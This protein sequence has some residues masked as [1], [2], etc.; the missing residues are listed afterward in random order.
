MTT[1]FRS[2]HPDVSIPEDAAIWNKLEQHASQK[3]DKAALICGMTERT[4]SFAQV[5]EQ[6]QQICAGLAAN[7]I[8][9]G[10]GVELTARAMYACGARVSFLEVDADHIL[11]VL[12]FFHIMATMIF[13]VTL[14]KGM[15]LI[16][17]PK[18]EPHSFLR[19]VEQYKLEN[20]NIAP[21]LIM[22]FAKHPA[23]DKYDVSAL[24]RLVSGG[25]PLGEEL[26]SAV[27]K[28]LGVPVMQSYGLTEL[29]GAATNS[30]PTAFRDGASGQLLPNTE[31][32]VRC[33]T[34]GGDLPANRRG[35]LLIRC[36]AMM[37]GY[38]NNPE[39]SRDAF[40]DDGFLRTGDVG[41]IDD[42]GFVFIIDRLK[43]MIK[44]KGHQVAPA[45]LEDV[46]NSHPLVADSCCV[47]GFD[48]A[49]GEEIPKA[50]VVLKDG[51]AALT[52]DGLMAFVAS[53][54]AGY[55]RVREVEFIDVIP[56]SLSGKILRRELQLV[57]DKTLGAVRALRSHLSISSF[58][59]LRSVAQAKPPKPPP[60]IAKCFA[61]IFTSPH[62]KIPIPQDQ[63]IWSM[64]ELH[65]RESGHKPAFICGL[66][67]KTLT[68]AQTLEKAKAVCAG[69]SAHGIKKGDIV[70]LHSFN[71]LEYPVVFLAL[72]RLGAICS[73]SSPMF[74][75]KE[76]ADQIEIAKATAVIGHKIFGDVV[77][78]GAALGGIKPHQV[79]LFGQGEAS[80]PAETI[81]YVLEQH[82]IAKKLPFPN[83][84]PMDPTNVVALP[85]SSGTTGR[86]KGV[87]LTGRA[88]LAT[89]IQT[90]AL[91]DDLTYVLGML[92]FFHILA[93]LI[94]HATIF[95]A[96][97]M[98]I[99]PRFEPES[100]LRVVVKYKMAKLSLAPPLVLFMA[101][102]PIVDKF[103]LSHVTVLASGGAP[104]GKE[105][106]HAIMKRLGAKVLQGYGMTEFAGAV[107]NSTDTHARDGSTGRLLP[108][109]EMKVK[110]LVT[111]ADLHANQTGE[112]L[113][114]TPSMMKG[115]YNNPEA[116]R[117]TF[118][119]DGFVRTGDIGYID[120]D[121]YVF[122]VDRL[123]ELIKY[124][125]HQVAPAELEDV[126][127]HH[128]SVADSC[129]VRGKDPETGEEIPKAFVVLTEGAKDVSEG[130][131][132]D[133]V[134]ER[135]AGFKRVRELEFIAAIPKSLAGKVLRKELQ[136]L[137]NHKIQQA[138]LR[139]QS[140]L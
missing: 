127:N 24:T 103:D 93:T 14:F 13:H 27:A 95:K 3:R 1:I 34:T 32:R 69:L 116:N 8:R 49:T 50:F 65:A 134:A 115:Y 100:F 26:K 119:E 21:P 89:A 133:F 130:E 125:G 59:H 63:T 33:L 64:L 52:S 140:R 46:L 35:E 85:F 92:P 78:E 17:L 39:A 135:V 101:K 11:A 72:N 38:F 98:V 117:A 113:F 121:G 94:F 87:E 110:D 57:Q 114:R 15:A 40:T 88:M 126:L 75:G 66:T 81:E 42:D 67:E 56:K 28:R 37:K 22:F 62:P 118:T 112:L 86:P 131:L 4:L 128:S 105:L 137:Q 79:Y 138:K 96:L 16:V 45:E 18:F 9:K 109:V 90:S 43:E 31:L 76:L 102:H 29:A 80:V 139:L 10:D 48:W 84:P 7:G 106:E 70:I 132:M 60:S 20:V 61:M 68:F 136:D 51:N 123:K 54:V 83:L 30:R 36:P 120:E 97:P 5:L 41:Y 19:V 44:Y 23:V 99:L 124:K 55:K 12:P 91:E 53:K 25:A 129:C 108:N 82:L 111:N 71:C 104:L 47:R 58:L 77:V 6:A 122:I 107:S 73:P 2:P 74:N